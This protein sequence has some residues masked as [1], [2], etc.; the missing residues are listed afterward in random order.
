MKKL[1]AMLAALLVSVS[2]TTASAQTLQVAHAFVEGTIMGEMDKK[3]TDLVTEKT[4]GKLKFQFFWAGSL[5]TGNEILN[6]L[7]DGAIQM[8]G[9][10]PVYYTSDLPVVSLTNGTP[11]LFKNVKTAVNFQDA[12][13]RSNPLFLAEYERMNIFPIL[14]HGLANSHLV[15]TKPVEKFEDLAGLKVRSFGVYLPAAIEALG[16]VPVTL[17]TNDTYEGLNR[18]VVDCVAMSYRDVI[19]FRYHEV[20]KYWTDLDFGASSGSVLYTSWKNYKGGGW[21]PEIVAAVDEVTKEVMD[22]AASKIIASQEAA[23]Q[24]GLAAGITMIEFK[25][26]DRVNATV[27]DM[28]TIWRDRQVAEGLD[29]AAVDEVVA[30]V[31]EAQADEK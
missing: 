8:G 11:F 28:L 26:Q 12:M 31:R 25:D 24:E 22:L 7:R 23:V 3:F 4:G 27:P 6:L 18:G 30:A 1:N 29:A 15:C 20:A 2:A 10:A 13:S 21:S 9:T 5:A 19:A 14:Q 17:G 16:M